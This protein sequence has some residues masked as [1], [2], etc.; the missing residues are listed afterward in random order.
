VSAS[1]DEGLAGRAT[2]DAQGKF[3]IV[4]L[5]ARGPVH[6]GV[7]AKGFVDGD[8]ADVPLNSSGHKMTV[9]KSAHVKVRVLGADGKPLE[10][11]T[12]RLKADEGER[13]GFILFPDWEQPDDGYD[14]ETRPGRVELYVQAPGY[15]EQR[16]GSWKLAPGQTLDAG[17]VTLSKSA[18]G[19]PPE[20]GGG[21]GDGE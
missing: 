4:R 8:Q 5:R 17:A 3:K 6:L 14:L 21:D 13:G 19:T 12:V 1:G 11:A 18:A 15:P 20:E 10:S 2:T 7:E 16:V 9:T